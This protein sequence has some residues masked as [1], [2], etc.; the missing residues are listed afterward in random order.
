MSIQSNTMHSRKSFSLR[1]THSVQTCEER[2][3]PGEILWVVQRDP[4]FSRKCLIH[5]KKWAVKLLLIN[6]LILHRLHRSF[7][8]DCFLACLL[9]KLSHVQGKKRAMYT[10][11]HTAPIYPLITI[12]HLLTFYH[13]NHPCRKEKGEKRESERD[14]LA[15]SSFFRWIYLVESTSSSSYLLR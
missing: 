14:P 10:P 15:T 12:A 1:F 5:R 11:H 6:F 8:Y 3:S 13:Q 7:L 4:H 9:W 2:R